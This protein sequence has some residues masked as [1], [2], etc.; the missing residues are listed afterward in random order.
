MTA[1]QTPSEPVAESTTEPDDGTPDAE[2]TLR[3]ATP[4]VK[5]VLAELLIVVL[6]TAVLWHYTSQGEL[7]ETPVGALVLLVGG[8]LGLRLLV[9]FVVLRSTRYRVTTAAV[10]REYELL[11]VRRRRRIPV[12]QLR[13]YEVTRSPVQTLLG[14]G[15]VSFLTGGT[16]ESLG[17]VTFEHVGD[18][19]G[20]ANALSE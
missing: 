8:L 19:D 9:K 18:P 2:R 10:V 3:E 15:T 16:N 14:Y 20:I 11:L 4:T 17:F 1:T 5:P 7:G 13:G 6:G 12:E